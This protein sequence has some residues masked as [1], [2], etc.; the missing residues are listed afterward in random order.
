MFSEAANGLRTALAQ[1]VSPNARASMDIPSDRFSSVPAQ[2]LPL[3]A[4]GFVK[5][6][7]RLALMVLMMIGLLAR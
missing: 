3:P 2:Q 7:G 4:Q 1:P 5:V 6:T